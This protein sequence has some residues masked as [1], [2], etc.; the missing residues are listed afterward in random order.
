MT[1]HGLHNLSAIQFYP[2]SKWGKAYLP[3]LRF[4][5]KTERALEM[6]VT[7]QIQRCSYTVLSS[8]QNQMLSTGTYRVFATYYLFDEC[9]NL[10][11]EKVT[12]LLDLLPAENINTELQI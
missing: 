8:L 7:I 11:E 10:L 1:S 9:F 6:H 3:G 12:H 4:V 2:A 5:I